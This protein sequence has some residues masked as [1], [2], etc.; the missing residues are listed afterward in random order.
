MASNTV[1]WWEMVKFVRFQSETKLQ[2]ADGKE[3]CSGLNFIPF[4]LCYYFFL[5]A[6]FARCCSANQDYT[7]PQI[8]PRETQTHQCC[9]P[10]NWTQRHHPETCGHLRPNK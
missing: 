10:D 2:Y 7:D 1:K 5:L 3:L 4:A 9:T 6:L 8:Y